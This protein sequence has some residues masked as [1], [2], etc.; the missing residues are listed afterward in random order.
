VKK[1]LKTILLYVVAIATFISVGASISY[2]TKQSA[3]A[4]KIVK[5]DTEEE[6]VNKAQL[7]RVTNAT[8]LS[9]IMESVYALQRSDVEVDQEV[10]D[11]YAYYLLDYARSNVRYVGLSENGIRLPAESLRALLE[12]YK[13]HN[14][15]APYEVKSDSEIN[16]LR[17]VKE[18]ENKDELVSEVKKEVLKQ[19]QESSG[20]LK[21]NI[22]VDVVKEKGGVTSHE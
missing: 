18:P 10:L 1:S 14:L 9:N 15:D 5:L 16:V 3:S 11:T 21:A 22:D 7:T 13:K 6:Q 19:N 20:K 17:T 12:V 8:I 4:E 2:F